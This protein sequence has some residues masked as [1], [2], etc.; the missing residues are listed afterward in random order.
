MDGYMVT[1]ILMER[2]LLIIDIDD[3][4]NTSFVGR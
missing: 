3:V 1:D 4:E 2:R